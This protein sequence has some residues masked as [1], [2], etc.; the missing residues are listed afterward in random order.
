MGVERDSTETRGL[1]APNAAEGGDDV[2]LRP[3]VA[4]RSME[5]VEHHSSLR[6]K[7]AEILRANQQFT[8]LTQESTS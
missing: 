8:A 2:L 7:R 5:F 1:A 3:T 6:R 4:C